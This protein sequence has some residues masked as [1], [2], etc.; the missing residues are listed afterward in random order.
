M[1]LCGRLFSLSVVF[2]RF[3]HFVVWI[4][5]CFM[6]IYTGFLGFFLMHPLDTWHMGC[7]FSF[8]FF[9]PPF[10]F[11]HCNHQFL[12]RHVELGASLKDLHSPWRNEG[13]VV[14]L[15][16]PRIYLGSISSASQPGLMFPNFCP[17]SPDSL[18]ILRKGLSSSCVMGSSFLSGPLYSTLWRKLCAPVLHADSWQKTP[19]FEGSKKALSSLSKAGL[20]KLNW[21]TVRLPPCFR[22]EKFY[23]KTQS[24]GLIYCRWGQ[25]FSILAQWHVGPDNSL[26]WG[27]SCPL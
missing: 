1:F 14:W 27:L 25:G 12:Q 4:M 24:Q 20:F 19:I 15:R 3:I 23:L 16:G 5:F 11:F 13:W 21:F 26:L 17:R 2:L 7:F 22:L 8:L 6:N 18:P 9:T 10:K